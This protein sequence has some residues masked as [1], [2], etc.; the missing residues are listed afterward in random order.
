MTDYDK[1]LN[2]DIEAHCNEE[3][4]EEPTEW[5][6]GQWR[7]KRELRDMLNANSRVV[8]EEDEHYDGTLYIKVRWAE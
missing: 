4:R 6:M 3:E 2:A 7:T 5:V 1:Q 8:F